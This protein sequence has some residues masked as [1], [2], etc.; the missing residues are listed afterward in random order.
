[1]RHRKKGRILGRT[2]GPRRALFKSL[3]ISLVLY[4]TIKTTE[5]K[6]KE[7]RGMVEKMITRG[8]ANTLTARRLLLKQ[9]G[10]ANA[11]KKILEVLSPRFKDR[12]GG[13]TRIIKLAPRAGDG[14]KM[15]I[16]EFV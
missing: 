2:T 8:K 1:M 16:I 7:L 14:A 3:A 13:Y 12:R 5:S 15:V 9:L 6:A 11:V 4:E 10:Q